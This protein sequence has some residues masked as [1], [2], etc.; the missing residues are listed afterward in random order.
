MLY[1]L[2][3]AVIL[4]TCPARNDVARKLFRLGEKQAQ[5]RPVK[6]QLRA[7]SFLASKLRADMMDDLKARS[8]CF[9]P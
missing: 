3:D 9:S 4:P 2:F 8:R 6:T 7:P 5:V 1:A